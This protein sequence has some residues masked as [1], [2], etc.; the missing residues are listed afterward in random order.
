MPKHHIIK[1][2]MEIFHN[3]MEAIIADTPFILR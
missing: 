2:L 3:L 1:A